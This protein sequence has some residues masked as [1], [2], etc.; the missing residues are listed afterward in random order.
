MN[1]PCVAVSKRLGYRYSATF[2]LIQLDEKYRFVAKDKRVV[3]LGGDQGG[4][5]QVAVERNKGLGKVVGLD[6]LVTEPI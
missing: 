6:I 1:D 2:K 3:G 5:T 4:W